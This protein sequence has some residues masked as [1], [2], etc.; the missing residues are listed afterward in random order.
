[1]ET[2]KDILKYYK[3]AYQCSCGTKYGSDKEEKEPFVCPTCEDK[4]N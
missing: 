4:N 3:F 1:M 2:D